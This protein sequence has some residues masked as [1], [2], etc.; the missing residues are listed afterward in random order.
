MSFDALKYV[1]PEE[2]FNSV[3]ADPKCATLIIQEM[4]KCTCIRGIVTSEECNAKFHVC[5]CSILT[6]TGGHAKMFGKLNCQAI[7]H[8]CI[9]G[10]LISI[11]QP[12]KLYGSSYC[13]ST[14]HQCTCVFM[15]FNG[16]HG[17]QLHN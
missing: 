4:N 10:D 17:C 6:R 13:Y 1:N 11:G 2:M 7:K 14:N 9:C 8:N 15:N 5:I 3:M 16:I 12:T